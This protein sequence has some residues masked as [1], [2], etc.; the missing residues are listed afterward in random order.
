MGAGQHYGAKRANVS[1]RMLNAVFGG[2]GSSFV[3]GFAGHAWDC[4]F[5]TQMVGKKFQREKQD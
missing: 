1:M 4:V 2:G 5:S 3:S